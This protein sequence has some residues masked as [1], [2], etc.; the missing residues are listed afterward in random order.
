MN[1]EQSPRC[2]FCGS[3]RGRLFLKSRVPPWYERRPLRLVECRGCGLVFAS[4]RPVWSELYAGHLNG[5]EEAQALY[6]R[7]LNRPGVVN[8]HRKHVETAIRFH[9]RSP[10]SLFDMGCGAGTL[11][12]A[13]QSLSLSAT[14]NDVNGVAVAEL[15]KKGLDARLGRTCDLAIE[16]RFDIVV[17]FDYI[18]HSYEPFRDLEVCRS[19]LNDDGVLYLKTLFLGS[20]DHVRLGDHWQLFGAGHFAFFHLDVLVAMV[21]AA[22]FRI[23]HI[24]TSNLVFLIARPL[25]SR[26]PNSGHSPV[27]QDA[28]TELPTKAPLRE[29]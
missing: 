23:E 10:R 22:G 15:R 11:M 29:N 21:R 16:S 24:T 19:L 13:A 8:V 14:G 26:R 25:P 12:E 6:L 5:S 1:W 4:P 17:C 9:G 27:T 18:E 28:S 20:P 3:A 7:K 2:G